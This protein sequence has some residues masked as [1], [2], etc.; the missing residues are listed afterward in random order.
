MLTIN[1]F[2]YKAVNLKFFQN[3]RSRLFLHRQ[4]IGSVGDNK[5]E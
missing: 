5:I 2:R 1:L 4:R 3:V